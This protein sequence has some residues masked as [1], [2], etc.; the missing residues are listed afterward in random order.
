[1][2]LATQQAKFL[3]RVNTS[4]PTDGGEQLTVTRRRIAGGQRWYIADLTVAEVPTRGVVCPGQS[5]REVCDL[6]LV[7]F[8]AGSVDIWVF[9]PLLLGPCA[10]CCPEGV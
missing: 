10:H 7:D 4:G 8:G 5:Y 2:L 3:F 6:S 9:C 1:M